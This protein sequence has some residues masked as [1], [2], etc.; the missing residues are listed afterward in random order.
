MEGKENRKKYPEVMSLSEAS[1][2]IFASFIKDVF[3]ESPDAMW[4]EKLPSEK[5]L[6]SL[7]TAKLEGCKE[8]SVVDLVLKSGEELMCEVEIVRVNKEKAVVGIITRSEGMGT[9]ISDILLQSAEE[10]AKELEITELIAEVK[11]SNRRAIEFFKRNGY[12]E[13]G[14]NAELATLVK[15]I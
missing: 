3:L 8:G 9:G 1:K 7:F 10:K 6:E 2:D 5:E 13:I 15:K 4:Y 11:Q 12:I 14:N